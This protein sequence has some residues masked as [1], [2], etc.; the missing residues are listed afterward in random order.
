[1]IA[2]KLIAAFILLHLVICRKSTDVRFVGMKPLEKY[3]G[4]TD[5]GVAYEKTYYVSD[6]FE[7]EAPAARSFCKSYGANVDLV[8]FESRSEFNI[9][10]PMLQSS[11]ANGSFIIVGGFSNVVEANG[12]SAYHWIASGRKIYSNIEVHRNKKC[13]GI[14]SVS[15]ETTVSLVSIS[16]DLKLKFICQD[17]DTQYAN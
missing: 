17:M 8:S 12:S 15:T 1:M 10:S 14:K 7:M 5:E 3:F 6:Y 11:V 13:L 16:C 4:V 9:V 2:L